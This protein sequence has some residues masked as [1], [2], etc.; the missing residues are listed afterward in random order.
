MIIEAIINIF[1]VFIKIAF[2][3]INLPQTPQGARTAVASYFDMIFNN[4]GFL[5]FFVRIDTIKTIAFV[6]ISV[7]T[8]KKLYQVTM[9]IIRKLPLSIN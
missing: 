4:L 9:W 3:F 8:F 2:A 5:G 6:A 1:T 7:I